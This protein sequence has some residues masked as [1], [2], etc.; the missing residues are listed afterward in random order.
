MEVTS[1]ED[2][3]QIFLSLEELFGKPTRNIDDELKNLFKLNVQNYFSLKKHYEDQ[4]TEFPELSFYMDTSLHHIIPN[5]LE[6]IRYILSKNEKY[7]VNHE[8]PL[9]FFYKFYKSLKEMAF[10][11]SQTNKQENSFYITLSFREKPEGYFFWKQLIQKGYF[12]HYPFL[13]CQQ[14]ENLYENL[15]LLDMWGTTHLIKIE[16]KTSKPDTFG[17]HSPVD[18]RDYSIQQDYQFAFPPLTL[19]EVI[20]FEEKEEEIKEKNNGKFI[21]ISTNPNKIKREKMKTFRAVIKPTIKYNIYKNDNEPPQLLWDFIKDDNFKEFEKYILRNP[22]TNLEGIHQKFEDKML[23]YAAREGRL[24]FVQFLVENCAFID[25]QTNKFKSTPLHAACF[26]Q[27]EKVA[28]FLLEQG[29][30]P[31]L[32]NK[33]D[34][35][36]I[37]EAKLK[38]KKDIYKDLPKNS[39]KNYEKLVNKY[40]SDISTLKYG[41]RNDYIF[42]LK[43]IIANKVISLEEEFQRDLS[44][45]DEKFGPSNLKSC[46]IKANSALAKVINLPEF[47]K[48]ALTKTEAIAILLYTSPAY[49]V[50]NKF[51]RNLSEDKTE[52][53]KNKTFCSTVFHI[54]Q[55]FEKLSRNGFQSK[56]ILSYR[57]IRGILQDSFFVP[58]AFGIIAFCDTGFIST[59]PKKD[60]IHNFLDIDSP[61]LI[62]EIMQYD[63]EISGNHRGVDISWCSIF[64]SENEV[65]FPPFTLFEIKEKKRIDKNEIII[66][67]L[68]TYSI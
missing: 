67:I 68:P 20:T 23:Y 27:H 16:I 1:N 31:F 50:I 48:S 55:A 43:E 65:L 9:S 45:N 38:N 29:A 22:T 57:G 52:F 66:K 53:Q 34:L 37:E 18:F 39:I 6:K 30:N 7:V 8:F 59:T 14:E 61:H 44:W 25:D 33:Y 17:F 24:K 46:W 64:K 4:N 3:K 54:Y 36:P 51:L 35:N 42:G 58:D 63:K 40:N 56:D 32:K 21:F 60:I 41:S 62:L 5:E 26:F 2:K 11:Q 19:F 10:Q 12:I 15:G 49:Y 28:I 13:Y 47:A